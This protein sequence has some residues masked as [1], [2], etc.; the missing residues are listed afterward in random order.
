MIG[1]EERL[2][3]FDQWMKELSKGIYL[4]NNDEDMK[5]LWKANEIFE[6]DFEDEE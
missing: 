5:V 2:K 6:D 3:N 1:G 4:Q